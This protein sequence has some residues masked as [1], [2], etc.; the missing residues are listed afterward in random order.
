MILLFILFSPVI[1]KILSE[2]CFD[3]FDRRNFLLK[4]PIGGIHNNGI[5]VSN[6]G[7][8][9]VVYEYGCFYDIKRNKN[10][11]VDYDTYVG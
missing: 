4:W 2:I 11:V 1:I 5:V 6:D 8:V 3:Y 10:D 9:A 7:N